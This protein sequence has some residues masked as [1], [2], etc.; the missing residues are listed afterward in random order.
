[1][2]R[3]LLV[4]LYF[5]VFLILVLYYLNPFGL[6]VLLD[7]RSTLLLDAGHVVNIQGIVKKVQIKEYY[8]ALTVDVGDENVLVRVK[9]IDDAKIYDLAGRIVNIQGELS[10]PNARR[11]PGCFDYRLYLK[12]QGIYTLLDT[13]KFRISA[14]SVKLH[15]VHLSNV[16]KGRFYAFSKPYLTDDDFGIIAGLLFGDKAYLDD[17]LYEQ[18]QQNGIAHVL[19]VSGLHVGLLYSIII[20]LLN[21][22][23]NLLSSALTIL[24][25]Y[26]YAALSSFSISVLRA[27]IMIVLDILA[28]HL[29]RRYDMVCGASLTAIIFLLINPYQL[30]DSGFQLSFVAAYTLGIMLPWVNNKIVKLSNKYKLDKS[31]DILTAI[32]PGICAFIGMAPLISFHFLNFSIISILLNPIAIALA[33]LVLPTGLLL[34]LVSQA[35]VTFLTKLFSIPCAIFSDSLRLLSSIGENLHLSFSVSAPPFGVLIVYYVFFFYFF[36]ETR[37]VLNRKHRQVFLSILA[38]FL[39]FCCTALPFIFGISDSVLPWKYNTAFVTF[40]DVGQGDCCHINIDGYNILIDGG[41]NYYKNIGKDTIKPY[42]LKNGIN[43]IDLAIVTHEDID[44]SKGLYELNDC[45]T[46][47]KIISGGKSNDTCIISSINVKGLDF[48]FMA[49]ADFKREEKF[50]LENPKVKAD[51]IKLG[52]HGSKTSSSAPFISSV[53]PKLAIISCGANNSYG[54]PA[55]RVIELL[56]EFDIIYGRTD[57][58]GA[59]S[60]I[61]STDDGALFV[62]AAK[63]TYW[64]IHKTK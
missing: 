2:R 62:N 14:D 46:I 53:A 35:N 20:K 3:P 42:L 38:S 28:F 59:I 58:N 63:D 15:V 27:S 30:F 49:D 6:S 39:I 16:L 31:Y 55:P 1:M 57:Q 23:K 19:A 22:K 37:Y 29:R 32:A 11:N 5:L 25:L 56:S 10:I 33:S 45:F 7:R 36:S 47:D 64:L 8:S 40:L 54:H 17:D 21:G 48:L 44:H 18:F 26:V 34:F 60:Y 41:G 52:H 61:K 12:A 13:S 4:I 24:F 43:K 50:L 51:V 9:G